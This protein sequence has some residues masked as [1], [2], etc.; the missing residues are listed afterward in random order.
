MGGLYYYSSRVETED[1]RVERVRIPVPGLP[2]GLDGFKI[3][4]L[5]DF[6]LFP[7]TRIELIERAV[8][9]A[10]ALKPDLALLGGDYV[11]RRAD[12]IFELAPVLARLDA[13]CGVFSILGNHDHWRGLATVEQGLRESRI[14]VLRNRGVTL[15]VGSDRLFLAGVDD[16]WV[17]R[18]DLAAA[19]DGA[20]S[21][22][23]AVVLMH[24]PDFADQF[25]ADRRISLQLSG[26][27][28]G[29]QV[30]F[31]FIG[32]PFLPPYGRKYDKGLY[33]VGPMWLYT[34]VGIGVTAP[35]R[36]NCPPEVS[37]ITLV[38]G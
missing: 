36:L 17:K 11:L 30:R 14:P 8:A 3:A 19:M 22:V 10:N 5:S 9:T 25:S 16:G 26:H 29:G 20:P 12:S 13:T 27:S 15:P 1:L 32:S 18:H 28:H 24:E 4:F 37:E 23:P 2:A 35:V 21:G 7:H 31:P 33:R 6:H 34:N 38:A